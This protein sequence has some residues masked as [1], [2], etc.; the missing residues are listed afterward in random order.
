MGLQQSFEEVLSGFAV[1][2]AL[3]KDFD[4]FSVLIDSSPQIV[5]YT[6]DLH[7][8]FIDIKGITKTLVS[9]FQ[10]SSIL[11]PELV[12]PQPD[13]FITDVDATLSKQ[14]FD[15]SMTEIESMIEPHRIS[16]N[17]RWKSVPL[18]SYC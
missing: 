5:L 16:N 17:F 12:T 11:G 14:V 9:A 2:P 10:T 1:A 6:I 3:Q 7:E 13:R 18:I 4:D 8:D 15:I